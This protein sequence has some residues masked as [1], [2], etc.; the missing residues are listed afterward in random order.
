MT[1][2]SFILYTEYEEL[3]NQLSDEQC[4]QLFKSVFSYNNNGELPEKLDT[5]TK[6]VFTVIRQDLDRNA[7]SSI[8]SENNYT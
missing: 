2:T 5:V 8:Y 4:G 1:K 6:I 3:I 7:N